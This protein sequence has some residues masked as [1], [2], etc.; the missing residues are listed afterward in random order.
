MLEFLPNTQLWFAAI[1]LQ[2]A[3]KVELYDWKTQA[4]LPFSNPWRTI[5]IHKKQHT[6][7]HIK[8]RKWMRNFRKPLTSFE[9]WCKGFKMLFS[10]YTFV[11]SWRNFYNGTVFPKSFDSLENTG[12]STPQQCLE[13][14]KN[15]WGT[16]HKF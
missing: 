6:K 16:T 7:S 3:H 9:N 11:F 8:L 15:Q 2:I 13:N 12:I 14:G 4:I 5:E 10:V 1:V